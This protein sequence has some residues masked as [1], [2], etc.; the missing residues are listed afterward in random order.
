MTVDITNITQAAVELAGTAL[1]AIGTVAI[2]YLA[3]WLKNKGIAVNQANWDAALGNAIQ[4]GVQVS[5]KEIATQGW[6]NVNTHKAILNAGLQYM[7]SHMPDMLKKVGLSANLDSE[8]NRDTIYQA[9]QRA[10]PYWASV[11]SA[12]PATPPTQSQLSQ[13][14]MAAVAIRQ[15]QQKMSGTGPAPTPGATPPV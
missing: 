10:L 13:T 7:A 6:D 12:S 8:S 15:A 11:A 14:A 1:T 4:Y 3:Q 5:N 2:T 9:L